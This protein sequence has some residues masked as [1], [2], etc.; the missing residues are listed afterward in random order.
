MRFESVISGHSLYGFQ[1]VEQFRF[2]VKT[3][4]TI[5]I[6][7]NF[8]ESGLEQQVATFIKYYNNIGLSYKIQDSYINSVR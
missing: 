6:Y 3:Q 4:F 2:I 8:I 1:V 5:T 7:T